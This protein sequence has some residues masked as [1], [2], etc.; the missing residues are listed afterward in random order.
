MATEQWLA[1]LKAGDEIALFS[2]FRNDRITKA[3]VL[4]LTNTQIVL[5]QSDR[6]FRRDSGRM[7]GGDMWERSYIGEWTL[8]VDAKW[9]RQ[10]AVSTLT[11]V[12][13]NQAP[14]DVVMAVYNTYKQATKK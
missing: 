13:W 8:D 14:T 1:D 11:G 2:G 7:I 10:V 12:V 3:K 5:E 6:R 4:R 9:R